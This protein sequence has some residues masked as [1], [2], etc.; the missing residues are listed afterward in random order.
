M[1]NE[2][3][4]YI[5]KNKSKKKLNIKKELVLQINLLQQLELNINNLS[6]LCE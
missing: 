6:I 1:F 3:I 2:K 5:N 4:K